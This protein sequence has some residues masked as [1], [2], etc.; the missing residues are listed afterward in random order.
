MLLFSF[1]FQGLRTRV[2][3][4]AGCRAADRRFAESVECDQVFW[5]FLLKKEQLYCMTERIARFEERTVNT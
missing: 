5:F 3:H 1:R 4:G 2:L